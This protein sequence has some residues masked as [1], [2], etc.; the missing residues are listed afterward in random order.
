MWTTALGWPWACVA[1]ND[2]AGVLVVDWESVVCVGIAVTDCD[3]VLEEVAGLTFVGLL[4]SFRLARM[5][6]HPQTDQRRCSPHR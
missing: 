5:H 1:G 3:A 4:E 6:T 2:S